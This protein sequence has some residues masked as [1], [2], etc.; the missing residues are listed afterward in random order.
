[1]PLT[2]NTISITTSTA[3]LPLLSPPPCHH[4]HYQASTTAWLL[5]LYP[6]HLHLHRHCYNPVFPSLSPSISPPPPPSPPPSWYHHHHHPDTITTRGRLC[7]SY[8]SSTVRSDF[9]RAKKITI[10]RNFSQNFQSFSACIRSSYD[11]LFDKTKMPCPLV[12]NYILM[13]DRWTT[14]RIKN[15]IS[16]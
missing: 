7:I 12:D 10:T 11:H 3:T 16:S 13:D 14:S 15:F 5:L 1:M 4:Y 6:H 8:L 9:V 2:G